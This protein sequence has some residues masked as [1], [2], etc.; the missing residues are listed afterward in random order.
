MRII[1]A[2]DSFKESL[3]A[4]DA[5]DA[6][7][8]GIRR[9]LPDA[10]VDCCPVADGGEGTVDALVAAT[11]GTL[12]RTRV[13]GPL[14]EPVEATWGL[15][16]ETPGEPR[17][18][19][20]EMAAASGLP[21]VPEDKRDPTRTT[22]FGTGQLIRAALDAHAQRIILGI[23][24][25]ATTDGGCGAA[26]ALDVRFLDANQQP[27]TAPLTGS[28]L[29][30]IAQID[31]TTRDPRLEQTELLVACDVTNP[32]LGE[33]GAAHVYG[34]QKGATP[35]QVETLDNA[36]QHL[37]TL[38]ERTVGYDVDRMAGAGAAGGLG[39]GAVALLG[40]R[41][42]RGI[43]LVL[44]AVHFEQRV[45]HCNLCLTGEGKLDG[46][47]LSGKAT[48]GVAR[49][50]DRF[51]VPTI[52]LVGAIGPEAEKTRE[53]GLH[54]YF[55]IGEGLEPAESMRR[56]AELLEDAAARVAERFAVR[57]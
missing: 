46:Q 3:T 43:E 31:L 24:G 25:S 32:L 9:T 8:R 4:R 55:A 22:T 41:L 45:A 6:M 16:G 23:G 7:A 10:D 21:L 51:G 1:C 52:A 47:S 28:T 27:I 56:A 54:R 57:G 40:G 13:T 18:A 39:G 5:A 2:P 38:I 15:L 11:D 14:G 26:Q 37:A 29:T 35:E 36:L 42:E 34:P 49:V 44:R 30:D 12:R 48:L 20:I 53:A 33:N 50:A 19:V 17:T